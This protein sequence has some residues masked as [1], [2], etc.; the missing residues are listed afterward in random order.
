MRS[1]AEI[2]RT[3]DRYGYGVTKPDVL[4]PVGRGASILFTYSESSLPA[5]VGY[6]DRNS[7]TITLGFPFESVESE[8]ERDRIM[9]SILTYLTDK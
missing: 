7:A 6:K 2:K 8:K 9:R 1:R 5:G 4:T 3:A